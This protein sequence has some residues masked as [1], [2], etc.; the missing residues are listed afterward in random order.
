MPH[1]SLLHM[2]LK[3]SHKASR[4]TV[5]NLCFINL[6]MNSK[7]VCVKCQAQVSYMHFMYEFYNQW[8]SWSK[9]GVLGVPY[10]CFSY[11]FST[12]IDTCKLESKGLQ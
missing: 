12:N 2:N 11:T 6:V 7:R 5:Q 10:A 4:M 9:Q 8:F 3:V 1:Q